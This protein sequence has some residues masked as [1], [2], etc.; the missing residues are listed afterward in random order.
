MFLSKIVIENFRCFSEGNDRFELPLGDGFTALVGE[1]EAGK[2][3]VIDALRFALGTTDQEW[4]RLDDSD[5]RPGAKPGELKEIRIV[6]QFQGLSGNDK[7]TFVEYLT[8]GEKS[9]DEPVLY[10]NW[11]AK[12][13]GETRKGQPYRRAKVNAGKNGDGPILAQEARDLLRATYLRPLRDAEESLSAGRGSRL[14]QV[15]RNSTS[16]RKG[17]D[18]Y[19]PSIPLKDQ[20]L[21][22]LGIGN[23]INTLL[24]EQKGIERARGEIDK[25][26]ASLSLLQDRLK[27][28]INVSGAMASPDTRLRELLEKLDLRLDGAGKVGLGSDNLLFMAC[29]LLLLAE[30]NEGNKMLLIEEP[31]AHLHPQ[32]Q[33]RVMRFLQA[34]SKEKGIQIIVTT[35]SPNLA[36]AIEL[37]NIVMIH[38]RRGYSLALGQTELGPCDYRFLKR[39]LDVTK[40]NLFFAR[41]VMIV[42]GDAENILLPTLATLLDR[43]FTESGVSIVNVGGVGLRRYARIFQRRNVGNEEPDRQL[44]I[45]VACITD[46][47]VMPDCAGEITGKALPTKSILGKA[48]L[49]ERREKL[50]EKASGQYVETF[51]S[52]EWTL[53]YD[54]ANSGLAEDVYVAAHLAKKEEAFDDAPLRTMVEA[55]LEAQNDFKDLEEESKKIV[56]EGKVNGC[57]YEEVLA[58]KVYAMFTKG[59]TASKSI[60]AQYLAER[61]QRKSRDG[62]LTSD[63]LRQRLPKYLTRAIDYVTTAR[64]SAEVAPNE[65]ANAQE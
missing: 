14:A 62:K 36:S 37:D 17:T 18:S 16:I 46:M 55:S 38:N 47:D 56:L 7:R 31:E 63:D 25:S 57:T 64:K 59:T 42:E 13:T 40:A 44:G 9:G 4:Y 35:H 2:T 30:E 24:K 11:T 28:D 27:S 22:V 51:V 19:D 52:D 1:N 34:Q 61:L 33:L 23:L 45:R 29:E 58:T 21:S 6:C 12:D 60:A 3:A 39:F 43:D 20:E 41:G 49:D 15:L 32:R 50:R 48:K 5:F 65:E 53:E 54:L 10:I 26:L 8:Y